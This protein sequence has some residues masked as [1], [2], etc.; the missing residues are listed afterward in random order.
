MSRS[1]D[2]GRHLP[3]QN[4]EAEQSVLGAILL[5]GH[6]V[7]RALEILGPEDFYR[8]AHRKIFRAMMELNQRSEPIDVVTLANELTT[9]GVLEEVGGAAYLAEL[10]DKVPTAANLAYYA[11]IVREKSILRQVIDASTELVALA[12][13]ARPG[14]VDS[15]LDRAEHRIFEISERRVRPQFSAM[16]DLMLAAVYTLETL[17]ERRGLLTGVP[18]GF[19]DLDRL[20]AGLQPSDLV[21]VAARPAMGKTAFALNT[22]VNAAIEGN[23]GVA[24]FSLE[25]SKQQL[26]LRMLC[27]EARVDSHLVRTGYI[28]DK[29]FRSIVAAANRLS[30]LPIYIDDT[31]G[32]SVLELRAKARR[33]KRE[34]EAKLGLIIVDYLQL[35]RSHE[36]MDSREQEISSI[37][38]SLKALAKELNVPVMALS[39][40]NRQVEARGDKRPQM[41]DLRESGA[42][43]QDAD[44]ILFLYRPF[45]YT[46]NP[47]DEHKAEVIIGKQ[48]NGPIDKV[49]LTYLSRYTRFE[50]YTDLDV[51][52]SVEDEL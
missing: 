15:F 14:E 9:A 46:K 34:R 22:A 36:R 23:V 48:R 47:E 18:T 38:R 27:A 2:G 52:V 50:N 41:A 7:D 26:A 21:I 1:S 20:T 31:P 25:M 5:D 4:I 44:V 51:A 30:E 42:I 49:P 28:G 12:Y 17:Y 43:E 45:V 32:L 39:Q 37:S 19:T 35:M 10:A 33:L 40:L 24:V 11:Q 29:D 8:D 6:A 13:E 16:N 3:P